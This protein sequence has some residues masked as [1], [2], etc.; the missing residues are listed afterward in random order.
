M[1]SFQKLFKH[2]P[3]RRYSAGEIILHQG[4]I[5]DAAY[6]VRSGIVKAY[7]I[8]ASGDEKPISFERKTDILA[9]AWVFDKTENNLF[10]YEAYTDT[11]VHI[12]PKADLMDVTHQN[13]DILI[14]LVDKYVTDNAAKSLRLYALEYSKATD[15]VLHMLFYLCQAYGKPATDGMELIDL[16]LTQQSLANLLGLTRE[17]TGM[18]LLKLK[19]AGLIS[20]SKRRYRVKKS[21]LLD[22]IGDDELEGLELFPVKP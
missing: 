7:S 4:E 5:P 3:T 1:E 16:P 14:F 9:S 2:Y 13:R 17:T 18:E 10:F 22:R 20:F 8:S 11:I 6:V 15:K 19:K 12:V 21:Q